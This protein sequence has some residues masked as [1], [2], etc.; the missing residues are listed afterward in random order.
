MGMDTV[1]AV[2]DGD[3]LIFHYRAALSIRGINH[4]GFMLQKRTTKFR[5]KYNEYPTITYKYM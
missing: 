4:I 5:N 1:C 3:G 2:M